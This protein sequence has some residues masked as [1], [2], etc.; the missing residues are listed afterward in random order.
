M[1]DT[2]QKSHNHNEPYSRKHMP[3]K[4]IRTTPTPPPEEKEKGEEQK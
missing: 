3:E 2:N 1:S 4:D